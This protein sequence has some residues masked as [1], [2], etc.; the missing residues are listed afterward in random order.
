MRRFFA[1]LTL[2]CLSA[3]L[4]IS[5]FGAG[6][7]SQILVSATV[8]TDES[9]YVTVTV[10]LQAGQT[11]SRFPVPREATNVSLSGNRVSTQM[12]EQAQYVEVS[13]A[14]LAFTI[15]YTLPD[16]IHTGPGET[17]E[18]QLP[19]LSGYENPSHLEF[20]VTLPGEI[21]AK[22]AFSSGYHHANI[23]KDLTFQASGVTVQGS[24]VAE[25]KDHETLTM[26]L[27]VEE[28]LFPNAPVE[29]FGTDAD[30][31]AIAVCAVLAL[32]YWLFF[33]ASI[34]PR[35]SLSAVAPE[36]MTAGQLGAVLT[37]GKADLSLMV[38]SWAGLGYLQLQS[39]KNSVVLQ[40]TMDMGNERTAFEQRIFHMLFKKRDSVDTTGFHY[41]QL[42]R[43]VAKMPAGI[44]S[45]V[46][47]RSGNPKLFRAISALCCLFGGVSFGITLSQGGALQGFWIFV[48]ALLG[49]FCGLFMQLPVSELFVRK[50]HK[51]V[52]GLVFMVIWL[53]LGLSAGQFTT[54]VVV[55]VIQLVAGFLAFYGG[56]R[57][58]QGR[59]SFAQVLG[60]RQYLKTVPKEDLRRIQEADPE[61]F[62]SLA[63]YALALGVGHS[64]AWRFGKEP[65]A[66]CP[67][68]TD[69][70]AQS[71]T[72]WEW[73]ELM[74]RTLSAMERRSKLLHLERLMALFSPPKRK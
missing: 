62:H 40:K 72:A 27:S 44:S 4:A 49:L 30:E 3:L 47:A 15:S 22:P 37:L 21:K 9:C 56:K 33:M 70:K 57:T 48:I 39:G 19:L 60:L 74:S 13:R 5:V 24:S 32:L 17:P 25:L 31:I 6:N 64:F 54:A 46:N 42:C 16:V 43:E 55:A 12:A 38:F 29:F 1:I 61:Y 2:I 68:I 8:N 73:A 58:E 10:T 36:G 41:A 20:T 35:R 34:P 67:Y 28:A 59:S 65:I 69:R 71:Y 52:T 7:A 63:P 50:S 26:T 18:L 11:V 53:L 14:G 45:L 66:G 51:T 23:E